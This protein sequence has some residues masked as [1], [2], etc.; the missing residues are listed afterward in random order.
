M[1]KTKVIVVGG[2]LAGLMATIK[3]L[4]AGGEVEL[5]AYGHS[6]RSHSACA[7]GGLNAAVNTVGEGDTTWEHFDDTVYGGDF[8]ADQTP[9]KN[10]CDAAPDIV[11]LFDRLGTMFNRTSEGKILV[12][13][14]GG[15]KYSRTVFSGAT[16]GQQLLYSLDEQVRRYEVDGAVTRYEGWEFLSLILDEK[17]HCQGIVA[18][19]L[20]DMQI[21]SFPSDAVVIATGGPGMLFK[22]TTNS[23]LNTGFAAAQAYLQGAMYANGEF[24]QIHPTAIPGKD[25]SRLMSEAAR[26]EGGRLWTYKDGKPFYFLEEWYPAYGNLVPRDIASRGVFKVC[27]DMGLGIDGR[28]MVYLDLSHK[29]PQELDDKL[30]G[31]LEIYEKFVGED[32]R[33]TPMKIFP[34]MHYSMGGLWVDFNQMTNIPGLFAAG[35]CEFL[36]HGANRL[37][38]NG[39]LSAIFGG[40]VAGKHVMNYVS[41]RESS[42]SPQSLFEQHEKKAKAE[43]D[44]ILSMDGKENAYAL[45]L[46]LG[47]WMTKNVTVVRYNDRLR[48]TDDK[49]LELMERWKQIG[50]KNSEGWCNQNAVFIRQ[51]RGRLELARVVTLGALARNESR[52]AHYKPEFPKRNDDE[53]LKTTIAQ[54]SKNEPILSYK[55]VD[56]SYIKPR[57]RKYDVIKEAARVD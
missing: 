24:I 33:K 28:N 45:Q 57:P 25:K 36:Y 46:E 34:A 44:K 47:E 32:P 49:I 15:A 29:D 35:E 17:G 56:L 39:M 13:R 38:G 4:E 12:R 9:V 3:V 52:G 23:T 40:M 31:I 21:K 5:F 50:N 43:Y 14:L 19:D 26:G 16:T 22:E 42:I 1:V 20:V 48:E 10:M 27:V 53:W 2:G 7:Q 41:G 8:L 54:Y 30:G 18:Q 6:K 11:Y 55:D 37:G 51:L